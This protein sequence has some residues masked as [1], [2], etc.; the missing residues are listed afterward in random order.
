MLARPPKMLYGST[1]TVPGDFLPHSEALPISS[2]LRQL[3]EWV[4]SLKP[5]PTCAHGAEHIKFNVPNSLSQAQYV[6]VRKDGKSTPLQPPYDGPYRV[7]ER[8]PKHF[9]LQLG[10]RKDKVSIDRLKVAITEGEVQVA[11]PPRRGR[12]PNSRI[13]SQ[14]P[15]HKQ[16]EPTQPKMQTNIQPTYAQ[17]TS[18][19]GRTIKPPVRLQYM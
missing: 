19:R 17:V 7:L 16:T 4:E 5:V 8:D 6:Y 15:Q 10:S 3:R 2:H 9:K 14:Q 11:Q 13:D 12:P 1:L 18:S